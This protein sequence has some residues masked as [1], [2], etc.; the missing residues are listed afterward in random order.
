V[1][2]TPS[3]AVLHV[4]D[5]TA[6]TAWLFGGGNHVLPDRV[7]HWGSADPSVA[8]VDANG[9][10]RGVAPGTTNIVATSHAESGTATVTVRPP[11]VVGPPGGGG[12]RGGGQGGRGGGQGGQGGQDDGQGG[13]QG[14]GQDGQDLCELLGTIRIC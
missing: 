10:V 9:M 13:G 5:S 4:G 11:P 7:V 1:E 12:G 14:G 6:L 3:S 8:T 2:L